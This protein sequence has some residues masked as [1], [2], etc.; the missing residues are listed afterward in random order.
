MK[1]ILSICSLLILNICY[2]QISI[3]APL[4]LSKKY[5]DTIIKTTNALYGTIPYGLM[6]A[7][8]IV[9]TK[10]SFNSTLTGCD[11]DFF[12]INS[13][14]EDYYTNSKALIV[15]RGN[16]TFVNKTRNAQKAGADVLIIVDHKTESLDNILLIDDGTANDIF[17]PTVM[18]SHDDGMIIKDYIK[19][20]GKKVIIDLH[21]SL[22]K[23]DIVDINNFYTSEQ[24]EIYSYLNDLKFY[25][26]FIS[27]ITNFNVHY[28][29]FQSMFYDDDYKED[30]NHC[31]SL[32]KFCSWGGINFNDTN[33]MI[34]GRDILEENI[35]QKCIFDL[36][37]KDDKLVNYKQ[38][39]YGE[40][41]FNYM[42]N[43]EETCLNKDKSKPKFNKECSEEVSRKLE[44][45]IESINKCYTESF[46][47]TITDSNKY[48]LKNKLLEAS[49]TVQTN[50]NIQVIPSVT[51]N[52]REVF[53]SYQAYNTFEAICSGFQEEPEACVNMGFYK[54]SFKKDEIDDEISTFTIII[55]ILFVILLNILIV[56]ICKRYIVK[57]MHE[58]ID[59]AEM[60]GKINNVVTSYLAL[61]DTK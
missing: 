17:I 23:K 45:N 12:I 27:N 19:E 1:V 35:R 25:M 39:F 29:S 48:K 58:K 46:E 9:N 14:G 3:I 40:A 34:N 4:E 6:S 11:D 26:P 54:N 21:I 32:G 13:S 47:G 30:V 33:I 43:F 55:I 36:S 51:V 16:C 37:R 10:E 7:V 31:L 28:V 18:I 22:E 41:Y 44:L 24:L 38:A 49:T 59:S 20:T 5:K 56:Y 50:Y 61:R 8:Q 15:D 52:G 60:N 57:K 42:R 53:G 2:C